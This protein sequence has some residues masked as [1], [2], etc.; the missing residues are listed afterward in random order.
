M[1]LLFALQK[2]ASPIALRGVFYS[3]TPVGQGAAHC[4]VTPVGRGVAQKQKNT[5]ENPYRS[6]Q[7]STLLMRASG[8][9]ARLMGT[10]AAVN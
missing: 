4:S 5:K 1:H 9:S 8:I 2:G 7:S 10:V 6:A 3:V